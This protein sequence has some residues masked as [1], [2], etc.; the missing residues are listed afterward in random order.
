MWVG[1]R[2]GGAFQTQV[3]AAAF[4]WLQLGSVTAG[5]QRMSQRR[6]GGANTHTNVHSQLHALQA[7][8]PQPVAACTVAW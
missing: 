7:A 8:F 6:T 1:R 2:S 5:T 4:L 3:A